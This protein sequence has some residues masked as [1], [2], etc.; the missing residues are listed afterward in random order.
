MNE[1][2]KPYVKLTEIL[3]EFGQVNHK[4]LKEANRLHI[5]LLNLQIEGA[6]IKEVNAVSVIAKELMRTIESIKDVI[7]KEMTREEELV[8]AMQ[9]IRKALEEK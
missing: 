9:E 4:I 2:M 7:N 3:N 6:K 1:K 8:L 5:V